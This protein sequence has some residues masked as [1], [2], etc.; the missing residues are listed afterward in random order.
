MALASRLR[1]RLAQDDFKKLGI[2]LFT[3][4]LVVPLAGLYGVLHNQISFS[5][6]PEYF[7]RFK[8]QQFGLEGVRLPDRVRA[9]IVGFLAA[10]WMGVPVGFLVGASAAVH[11]S[12]RRMLKAVLE[13]A[14]IVVGVALLFGALGL[15][16]GFL[17]TSH[18]RAVDYNDWY[19]PNH[20]HHLR[21]FLCA[22]YMHN[23]SYLG[24]ALAVLAAW[25]Y[26]LMRRRREAPRS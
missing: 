19:I 11:P 26:Q 13:S 9:S 20:V 7:T 21:R 10:W 6:S 8:F 18:I 4:L 14:L 3:P 23:A 25:G 17:R 2:V 16:F 1:S 24:A 15:A 22:A 5:V 12:P